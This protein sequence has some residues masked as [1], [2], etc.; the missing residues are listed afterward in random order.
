MR[1]EPLSGTVVDEARRVIAELFPWEDEHQTALQAALEP[2]AFGE[3]LV[4]RRLSRVRFWTAS[5][6]SRIVGI[7]GLYDYRDMPTET[8]LSWFGLLPVMRGHG[9]GARL[10]DWVINVAREEGREVLRLWTTDEEEYRSA[11]RLYERRGF[12]SEEYPVLPDETWRTWVMSLGLNGT[13]PIPW[14]SY[15]DRP[16]LCGRMVP[17]AAVKVA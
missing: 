11:I 10:L 12:S 3:F 2:D 8:W 4:T 5:F 15:G 16:E 9:N 14:L 7:A 13:T 6:D 17:A 1:I